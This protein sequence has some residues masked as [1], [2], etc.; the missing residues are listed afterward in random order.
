VSFFVPLWQW[1]S[2]LHAVTRDRASIEAGAHLASRLMVPLTVYSCVSYSPA[3]G[4][5]RTKSDWTTLNFVHAIK[6][7]PLAGFAI[8]RVADGETVLIDRH[9]AND[10]PRWFARLATAAIPWRDVLPCGLVPIP[11]AACSLDAHRLP[12][13]HRLAEALASALGPDAAAVDLFRWARPM[14]PA[15]VVEDSRDPQ[16]L[17]GRLCLQDRWRPVRNQRVVLVDD[18]M[19]SGAHL[20]AAAAFLRDCGAT[21]ICAVCA[22]RACHAAPANGSYLSPSATVLP[23]FYSDPGWH[24]PAVYDGIEL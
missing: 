10:A 1:P 7:T 22:A 6:G 11:D 24:L 21:P 4:G 9:S 17:Y 15:H 16:V 13:T 3:F 8:L 5:S 12:R 18:V 19:A 23:D 14:L 20:R 2:S